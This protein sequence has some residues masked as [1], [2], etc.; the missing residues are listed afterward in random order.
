MN[1]DNRKIGPDFEPYIVAEISANH[2]GKL[3]KALE[4]IR[5]AKESGADAVKI[6]TYKSDSITVNCNSKDFIINDGLWKGKTLYELYQEA[7]TPWEWHEKMFNYAR[8]IGITIFSSP[9]DRAA[10]DLLE[11]LGTP[12]YKIASFEIV[13]LDLISYTAKTCKPMIISTGLA[14]LE[15]IAEAVQTA[16]SAGCKDLALLHCVSG[17]PAPPSDY[18]LKTIHALASHFNL[19]IGLSDHTIDNATAIA[20]VAFGACIIEKHF[21]LSRSGGGP[22]DVFS[23]EPNELSDLCKSARNAWNAIGNVSF[24]KKSSEI[25]NEKFR[26]SLYFI[27]DLRVGQTITANDVRSIRPGFGLHPKYLNQIIGRKANREITKNT[28]VIKKD[29]T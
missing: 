3:D 20:S 4:L 7:Q 26:R 24:F 28:P 22:D 1:I 9:F 14:T 2:G 18:N 17:Y 6:Q 23:I 27:N 13:D 19:K 21:T 8:K 5:L 15:D 10:V 11:S 16:Q 12:A 29:L 25:T